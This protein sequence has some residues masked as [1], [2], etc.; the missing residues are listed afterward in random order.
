MGTIPVMT[1]L[2]DSTQRL[3][4]LLA[5][6]DVRAGVAF[7]NS[8]T[9]HRFTSLYRFDRHRLSNVVFY[10][11]ENPDI[12][13]TPEL[14]VAASYCVFVRDTA[15]AFCMAD[16][17]SDERVSGH[18]KQPEIRAYCGVPLLDERGRVFGT[19]CHFDFR[20][21][22]TSEEN[23]ALMESVAPWLQRYSTH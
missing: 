1:S 14:P 8:L 15:D 18:S 12:T 16:S 17:F 20:P 11:R 19:L 7:L 4:S 6:G 3:R 10:D 5:T 13:S 9:E 23:L 22:P 2:K 21:L